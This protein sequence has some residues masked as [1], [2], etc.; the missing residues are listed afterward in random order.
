MTDSSTWCAARRIADSAPRGAECSA[1]DPSP[2]PASST[3]P[4]QVDGAA[5]L[6]Q[7]RLLGAG[8]R[9]ALRRWRAAKGADLEVAPLAHETI[10]Y[11]LSGRAEVQLQSQKLLLEAGDCW[12]VPSGVAHRYRIFERFVAIEAIHRTRGALGEGSR[13]CD[14]P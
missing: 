14:G 1:L 8:K 3:F 9:V 2:A 5:Q 11:V 6:M 12:V 10:A 7:Y 4:E 13:G